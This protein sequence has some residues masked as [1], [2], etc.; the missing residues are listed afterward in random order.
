MKITDTENI[1][2]LLPQNSQKQEKTIEE[3][4]DEILNEKIDKLSFS[5][6]DSKTMH[7]VQSISDTLLSSVLNK[8]E[9][10]SR[11]SSFLDTLEEYS[12]S[13]SKPENSL[14]DI[15]PLIENIESETND[16][17]LLSDTLPPGD[18]IKSMLDEI[19]IRASV[20][21]IKFN[22]GDYLNP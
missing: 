9:M 14:K 19:L 3:S 21:T 15:N 2:N 18:Q 4:F 17:K 8:K 5:K 6:P 20:E 1:Q 10:V 11:V 16:L 7:R 12:K 13:L 22:R